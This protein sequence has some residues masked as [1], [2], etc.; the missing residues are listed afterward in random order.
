MSSARTSLPKPRVPRRDTVDENGVNVP[1]RC[2]HVLIQDRLMVISSTEKDARSKL[3]L[4]VV[5]VGRLECAGISERY[6]VK[7][8]SRA[9]SNYVRPTNIRSKL[10]LVC[11]P[12]LSTR[13]KSI[14]F[15]ASTLSPTVGLSTF[16]YGASDRH[17]VLFIR[18]ETA[19]MNL[20]LNSRSNTSTQ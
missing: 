17:F 14:V 7:L 15:H 16:S 8:T 13:R 20:C 4:R 10:V 18:L 3:S 11:L 6:M 5:G 1:N 2:H 19:F 12:L 9:L